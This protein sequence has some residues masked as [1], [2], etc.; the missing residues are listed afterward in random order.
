MDDKNDRLQVRQ[1]CNDGKESTVTLKWGLI[2]VLVL[3]FFGWLVVSGASHEG[4]LT[5]LETKIEILLPQI[6]QSLVELQATTTAIR[7]DQK[8]LQRGIDR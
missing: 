7:E 2:V 5:R 3:G 8:R 4:R 6:T 1:T